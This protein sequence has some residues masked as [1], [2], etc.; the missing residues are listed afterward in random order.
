MR[1]RCALASYDCESSVHARLHHRHYENHDRGDHE[2]HDR[3]FHDYDLHG[4]DH[5]RDRGF[6]HHHAY[7][8]WNIHGHARVSLVAIIAGHP[9]FPCAPL[10]HVCDALCHGC[11]HES[12]CDCVHGGHDPHGHVHDARDRDDRALHGLDAHASHGGRVSHVHFL[13]EQRGVPHAYVSVP[14]CSSFS[15]SSPY[16]LIYALLAILQ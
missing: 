3:G 16:Q 8:Q 2:L 14:S 13:H 6:S 15:Y 12:K 9:G 1:H 10:Y 11:G 5:D 7:G 4:Y